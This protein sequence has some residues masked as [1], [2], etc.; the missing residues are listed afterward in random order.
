ETPVSVAQLALD[1]KAKALQGIGKTIEGKIVEVVDDG[2]IHALTKRKAEVPPEVAT[3]MRLPGLGPKTARRIWQEMGITTVDALKAAA[4]AGELRGHAGIG[5]GTEQKIAEALAKPQA[6]EGPRRALLGTTLPK[7]QAAV[8][9]LARH[10]ASDKGSLA[11]SA[12]RMR[13]T[14]RDLDIIAT[15]SDPVALVDHF[16][17]LEWVVDIAAKGPTK[18]TV[19]S[20]DGLRFD[21]RVV[22]PASYG[23]LLQHFTG[24][25]HHNV[26]LREDAVRRGL[27]ISE[28]SVTVV[29][30]GEEHAFATEEEVYAFLGYAWIPPELRENGGELAAARARELPELVALGDLRGDLHTH[31]TWSDGKDTLEAMVATASR[32]G[33]EYYAVCDHSQRLRGDLLKRQSEAIDELN[34]VVA[35]LRILKG[36]EVNIRPD[37]SLDVEDEDLVTRD[38]VVA[39]VHS[40][41]DH[42]TTERVLSAM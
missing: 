39:S 34:E 13:E 4:E 7:R 11:G 8:E 27:S 2:E 31:T 10:P 19:V 3:F 23:N 26:A 36:I 12:R 40:R 15:A 14:V 37:G 18:A 29:E 35:P 30:T 38:W 32:R 42:N 9:E 41:F 24:S 17:A 1:G 16:C 5:A 20:Q 6:A 33:Y 25:K 22:E 28:Y 21:L